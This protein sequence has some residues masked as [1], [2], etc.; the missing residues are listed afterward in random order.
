MHVVLVPYDNHHD[1]MLLRTVMRSLFRWTYDVSNVEM[2]W[3]HYMCALKVTIV[4][5][6]VL[7]LNLTVPWIIDGIA[8]SWKSDGR[9]RSMS[10][11]VG[12]CT[13]KNSITH[14]DVSYPSWLTKVSW[15]FIVPS[16]HN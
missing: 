2:A 3:W 7:V 13:T 12:R 9:P 6:P 16:I 8:R 4:A 11:S 1:Q 5:D 14:M 10:S 15:R